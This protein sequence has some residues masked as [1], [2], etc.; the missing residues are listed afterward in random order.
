MTEPHLKFLPRSA[1]EAARIAAVEQPTTE[2]SAPEAFEARAGGASTV[3]RDDKD[4]FLQPSANLEAARGL[5]FRLGHGMFEKLWVSPPSSTKASDGLG[6]LYNARSCLSCHPRDGRGHAPAVGEDALSL[7]LHVARP[8]G[9][10]P[11]TMAGIAGFQPTGPDPVYGR[12]MQ[13]RAVV[14]LKPEYRLTVSYDEIAIPLEGGEIT[15][16]RAPQY[17]LDDLTHGPLAAGSAVSPRVAPAMIGLGLLEAIPAADILAGADPDDANGDGISGRAN[18]VWSQR[19]Q[20]PMLG[21][22]GLKAGQPTVEDQSARAFSDDIGISTPLYPAPWGDCTEAEAA[23][24]AAPHGDGDA[25]VFEVDAEALDVLVYYARNLAVPARRDVDDPQVLRGKQVFYDAGCPACHRPKFVTHRL[26]DLPEQSFQL[27][28]PYSD[29][30]LHDMGPGLADDLVEGRASGAEWRTAPLWGI[31][32]ARVVD[33][34]AGYLHDGRARSLLEAILWHGGEAQP[35][36]DRV[37]GLPP[38]ERA[39][40]IRFLESL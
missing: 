31:G 23:C 3:F 26:K 13:N 1:E 15:H 12:Q 38:T 20:R 40:L 24:R 32:L 34:R 29:L 19:Y 25:R 16:L 28:W 35:Q 33:P 39:A 21:R 37:I 5:D 10:G 22:F 9:Q 14:G 11:G 18:I 30:L 17:R 2:F 4:T 36:R 7:V 27:I 6:P 8:M